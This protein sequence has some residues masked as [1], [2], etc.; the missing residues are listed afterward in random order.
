[1]TLTLRDV[2]EKMNKDLDPLAPPVF[3]VLE[4]PDGSPREG[5]ERRLFFE[6]IR[7]TLDRLIQEQDVVITT[8]TG[9]SG[10]GKTRTIENLR[11]HLIYANRSQ[12]PPS[13]D[14]IESSYMIPFSLGFRYFLPPLPD[15]K[16]LPV[17]ADFAMRPAHE[18]IRQRLQ[19]EEWPNLIMRRD[20]IDRFMH[21]LHNSSNGGQHH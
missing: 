18:D 1:M 16:I 4:N 11:R 13:Y 7:A 19:T 21:S 2:G 8:F 20:P 5:D 3:H 12:D 6:R 9:Y 15:F 10:A 17:D 14:P